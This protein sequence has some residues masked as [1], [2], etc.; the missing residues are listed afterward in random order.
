MRVWW[1]AS[2]SLVVLG[3]PMMLA[4][5]ELAD[6]RIFYVLFPAFFLAFIPIPGALGLLIAWVAAR[7]VP[8][9]V[10][11][12]LAIALGVFLTVFVLWG[13]RTLQLGDSAT[14]QWLMSF[15]AR[16]SF[17]ES[18]FLPNNWVATGIDHAIHN[19]FA[20]A[21][22]YLGVTLANAFFL[23]WL[24]VH[25]VSRYFHKALDRVSAGRGAD[26]YQ[27]GRASGGAAG[28]LFVYLPLRLRLIAAKDLRTFLRDPFAVEPARN[29]IRAA[30]SL[31]D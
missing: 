4:M 29:P 26:Q 21:L 12:D 9:G 15:Y 3:I 30:V 28:L 17:I 25:V 23:S 19:N 8:R 6:Q 27:A 20:E 14:E 10:A 5:A 2:W 16:M 24:A 1:L 11:R 7:F 18:A 22:L 13:M 31:S